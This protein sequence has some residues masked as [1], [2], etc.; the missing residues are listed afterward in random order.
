MLF[1][2]S[3]AGLEGNSSVVPIKSNKD[4]TFNTSNTALAGNFE[5][6]VTKANVKPNSLNR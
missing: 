6:F 1:N 5:S 4:S 3:I 2:E